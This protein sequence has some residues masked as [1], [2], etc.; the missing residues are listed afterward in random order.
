M[1]HMIP[2]ASNV[3]LLSSSATADRSPEAGRSPDYWLGM[4]CL[5]ALVNI[6][7]ANVR[8]AFCMYRDFRFVHFGS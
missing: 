7:L 6:I 8:A 4:Y 1:S 3:T 2:A 5:A